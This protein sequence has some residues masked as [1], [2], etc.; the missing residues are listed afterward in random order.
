VGANHAGEAVVVGDAE[1]GQA[2]CGR[3]G[4]ELLRMAGAAQEGIVGGDLQLRIGGGH[5]RW[6]WLVEEAA[7]SGR[8]IST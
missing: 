8:R 5:G 3:R 7:A 4:E 2:E 1:G 6:W